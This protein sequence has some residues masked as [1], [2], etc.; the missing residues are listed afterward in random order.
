[1]KRKPDSMMALVF[2]FFLGLAA[3]S[4][5]SILSGDESSIDHSKVVH[6]KVVQSLSDN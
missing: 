2:I 1:M 3:T 6:S 4:F 5:A